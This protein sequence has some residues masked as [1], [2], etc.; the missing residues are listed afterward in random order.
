MRPIMNVTTREAAINARASNPP[1]RMII[2]MIHTIIPNFITLYFMQD[3]RP[4]G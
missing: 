4:A 2:K 3:F 1:K